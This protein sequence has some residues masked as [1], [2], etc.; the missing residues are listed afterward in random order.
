MPRP[1]GGDAASPRLALEDEA[2]SRPARGDTL[3][4]PARGD[5]SPRLVWGDEAS[6]TSFCVGRRGGSCLVPVRE[7]EAT[8]HPARGDETSPHSCAGRGGVA[9]FR[10]GRRGV[11]SFLRGETPV[12]TGQS[13]Y[14]YLVEPLLCTFF[15]A[16]AHHLVVNVEEL[17]SSSLSSCTKERGG[18][19]R[20]ER[21]VENRRGRPKGSVSDLLKAEDWIR[22]LEEEVQLLL[23]Q[24]MKNENN[25][26]TLESSVDDAR[27]KMEVTGYEIEK[28]SFFSHMAQGH[29]AG[30]EIHV[31]AGM[32]VQFIR[33]ICRFHLPEVNLPD[34]F[35][36]RASFSKSSISQAY[37]QL[38]LLMSVAQEF[39]Y[40][41]LVFHIILSLIV[42]YSFLSV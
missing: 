31:I 33:S 3:P 1:P 8:L 39:H 28:V 38:K 36:L 34:S 11:A 35:F 20:R 21:R 17:L 13:A 23:E 15:I 37:N 18:R 4:R 27:E 41:V 25:I 6:P 26:Q 9:L 30:L 5:A 24:S 14:R 16:F 29:A 22:A 19:L 32:V 7:D 10:T 12:S 42:R 40:E 2:S